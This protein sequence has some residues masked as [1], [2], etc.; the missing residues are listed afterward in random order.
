MLVSN[1]NGNHRNQLRNDIGSQCLTLTSG[2]WV[3]LKETRPAPFTQSD[4]E[5]LVRVSIRNQMRY[6]EKRFRWQDRESQVRFWKVGHGR[7]PIGAQPSR[8]RKFDL[9]SPATQDDA[10]S[11]A[12]SQVARRLR[13]GCVVNLYGAPI[14]SENRNGDCL[15]VQ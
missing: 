15:T 2:R 4:L 11:Q 8:V 1:R 7:A 5:L 9:I 13:D 12:Q 6:S 10:G 3:A 14:L